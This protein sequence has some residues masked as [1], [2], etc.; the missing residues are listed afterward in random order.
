MLKLLTYLLFI[1][2]FGGYVLS[3]CGCN[4]NKR[5]SNNAKPVSNLDQSAD[6]HI[7]Q[8]TPVKKPAILQDTDPQ[9]DKDDDGYNGMAYIPGGKIFV[10]TDNPIFPEDK[11]APK[12]SL[13]IKSFYLEKYEV[14]NLDFKKFVD[15]TGHKTD[16]EVFGDS[17]I[18]KGLISKRMQKKYEDFRV[19]SAPWWYKIDKATWLNP[20]GGKSNLD[21]E[22]S[23]A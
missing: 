20:E 7:S 8:A 5:E 12:R 21:G 17:F 23:E 2:H 6:D 22:S 4:K 18:F 11:E 15:A 3:D 10:G 16:A 9:P 19:A 1:S 14:S 13:T